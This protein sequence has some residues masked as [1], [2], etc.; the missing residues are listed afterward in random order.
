MKASFNQA[1]TARVER[2]GDTEQHSPRCCQGD[3][4]TV[5]CARG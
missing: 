4:G 2:A 5:G 3:V 1:V